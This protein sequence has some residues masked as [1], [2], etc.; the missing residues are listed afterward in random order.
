MIVEFVVEVVKMKMLVMI[1]VEKL[2]GGVGE[3]DGRGW[4]WW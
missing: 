3:D 4:N 1:E 2:R